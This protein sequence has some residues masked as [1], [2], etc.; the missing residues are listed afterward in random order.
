MLQELVTEV[1]RTHTL[2][3]QQERQIN[4][5]LRQGTPTLADLALLDQLT[6]ALN[7]GEVQIMASASA[8]AA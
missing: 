4:S 6:D 3:T 1:L 7:R 8:R 5:W 2:T